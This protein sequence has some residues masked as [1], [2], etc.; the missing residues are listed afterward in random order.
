MKSHWLSQLPTIQRYEQSQNAFQFPTSNTKALYNSLRHTTANISDIYWNLQKYFVIYTKTNK[1]SRVWHH[2]WNIL[3]KE[4]SKRVADKYSGLVWG[5]CARPQHIGTKLVG[6]ETDDS[7]RTCWVHGWGP[8]FSVARGILSLAAEFASCYGIS[9]FLR[10][11]VLASNKGTNIRHILVIFRW[12][13]C[14]HTWFCHE[15][16]DCRLG[17]NGRNVETIETSLS[18]DKYCIFV[19]VQGAVK[20]YLLLYVEN[21]PRWAAEFGKLA[22]GIW[23]NLPRNTVVPTHGSQELYRIISIVKM[24]TWGLYVHLWHASIELLIKKIQWRFFWMILRNYTNEY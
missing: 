24:Q 9:T 18:G 1:N 8:Q 2:R 15:I 19:R 7:S 3:K 12:P 23:K 17:R 22:C 6:L 21:L 10:N 16:H 11:L 5:M 20:I 4:M 14:M 13:Y